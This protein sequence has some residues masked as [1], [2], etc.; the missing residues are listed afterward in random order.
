[1]DAW[2]FKAH[3]YCLCLFLSMSKEPFCLDMESDVLMLR[4]VTILSFIVI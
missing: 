2:R 4:S 1:M 3:T